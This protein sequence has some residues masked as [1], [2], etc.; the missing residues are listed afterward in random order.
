MWSVCF[1]MFVYILLFWRFKYVYCEWIRK[2]HAGYTRLSRISIF[3]Y[4]T[5]W[6][7]RPIQFQISRR[8]VTFFILESKNVQEIQ[9]GQKLTLP[10]SAFHVLSAMVKMSGNILL[11]ELVRMSEFQYKSLSVSNSVHVSMFFSD[12]SSSGIY[13][14]SIFGVQIHQHYESFLHCWAIKALSVWPCF[15]RH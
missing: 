11:N 13:C 7:H 4:L 8:L 9:G 14:I 6:F 5:W 15:H 10:L 3:R 2:K 12:R 1:I